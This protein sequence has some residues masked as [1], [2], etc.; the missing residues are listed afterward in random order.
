MCYNFEMNKKVKYI[1][2]PLLLI[3]AVIAA[4]LLSPLF[5][6]KSLHEKLPISQIEQN[7]K[8]TTE[9]DGQN[10]VASLIPSAHDVQ[11]KVLVVDVEGKK[12]IRFENFKTIN[13]PDLRIYLSSSLNVD[14][15][16]DLGAIKAT[17]GEVNYELPNNVDLQKYNNVLVWC[18]AFKVLFSYAQLKS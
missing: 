5:R 4:F 1:V 10:Y 14:D 7:T 3:V 9:M 17:E 13:G 11:G 16:I 6:K 12:Y 2:I 15:S 18:R 8:S